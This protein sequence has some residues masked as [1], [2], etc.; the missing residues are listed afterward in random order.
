MSQTTELVHQF[1][2]LVLEGH[3]QRYRDVA[4]KLLGDH[5]GAAVIWRTM[6][7]NGVNDADF[8]VYGSLAP[9][10]GQW[11]QATAAVSLQAL[12]ET[13]TVALHHR[14]RESSVYST[15]ILKYRPTST[16]IPLPALATLLFH[17]LEASMLS[18]KNHILRDEWLFA[19]GRPNRGTAALVDAGG[20]LYACSPRFRVLL[21]SFG[22]S[23]AEVLPFNLPSAVLEANG[24]FTVG[25]LHIRVSHEKPL[26]LIQARKPVVV[27]HLS[28]RE[29]EI[30]RALASGKT[31]KTIARQYGI[32]VSTVA[33]HASRIYKKLN[34]YR[35]EDLLELVRIPAD[36][37]SAA[38]GLNP[39]KKRR[40]KST[41][42]A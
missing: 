30:A 24:S 10:T 22:N 11:Q 29:Q 2:L 16:L 35:R 36:G 38:A 6:G 17:M 12:S 9:T 1:Y 13:G 26:Y 18:M 34:I 3:W 7:V 14:H 31:F 19:M 37:L 23:S 5:L 8:S 41:E 27:D 28:P 4:L 33:N 15:V 20:T 32:A 42:E 21:G 39:P 40:R 25:D